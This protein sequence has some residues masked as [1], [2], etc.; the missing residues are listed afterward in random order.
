MFFASCLFCPL[1]VMITTAPRPILI[2]VC[3][4]LELNARVGLV[5]L[6]L[7]PRSLDINWSF[8]QEKLPVRGSD[9]GVLLGRLWDPFGAQISCKRQSVDFCEGSCA[10]GSENLDLCGDPA[11]RKLKVW[12]SMWDPVPWE[13][14]VM[15][16]RGILCLGS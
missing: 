1:N 5:P 6:A 2:A 7:A 13:L 8:L 15:I 3:S 9:F 14:K 10:W 16:L 4:F 12:I 11:P